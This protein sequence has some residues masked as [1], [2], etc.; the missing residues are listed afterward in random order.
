[1]GVGVCMGAQVPWF[2]L[3]AGEA[4]TRGTTSLQRERRG[5]IWTQDAQ[6]QDNSICLS[7]NVTKKKAGL[8]R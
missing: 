7:S 5:R 1:M 3:R 4:W 8:G 2:L 6:S